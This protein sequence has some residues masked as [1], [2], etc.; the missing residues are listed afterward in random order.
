MAQANTLDFPAQN[1]GAGTNKT[2]N[3]PMSTHT[4][5]SMWLACVREPHGHLWLLMQ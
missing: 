1:K 2:G 3:E 4:K 5:E